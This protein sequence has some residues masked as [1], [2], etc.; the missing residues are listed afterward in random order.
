M[1]KQ[2]DNLPFGDTIET[3]MVG[4]DRVWERFIANIKKDGTDHIVSRKP[5]FL[6]ADLHQT[7]KELKKLKGADNGTLGNKGNVRRNSIQNLN[8]LLNAI[9]RTF[10]ETNYKKLQVY[11]APLDAVSLFDKKIEDV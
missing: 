9:V 6:D 4:S 11:R 1:D 3:P 10:I 7:L 2:F 5:V 8:N